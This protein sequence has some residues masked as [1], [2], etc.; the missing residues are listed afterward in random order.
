VTAGTFA[1]TSI[2]L[3]A[4]AAVAGCGRIGLPSLHDAAAQVADSPVDD[5]LA[6]PPADACAFGP[7]MVPA[8]QPFGMVN[9][10]QTDWGVEVSRD[11]LRL[12]FSSNRPDPAHQDTS[13]DVYYAERATTADGFGEPVRLSVNSDGADD[14]DPTLSEDGRELYFARDCIYAATRSPTGG[15]SEW[16]TPKRLDALCPASIMVSGPFLSRDGLRLYYGVVDG[17]T[18]EVRMATRSPGGSFTQAG[19]SVGAPELH[20]IALDDDERTL[21]GENS[22]AGGAQLWR[23]TRPSTSEPFPAGALV[24]ELGDGGRFEDG[25]PSLT[26]D[27]RHLVFATTR[28]GSTSGPS[29]IVI[30]ERSCP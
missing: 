15:P 26:S 8:D 16:S 7:W 22:S 21:Y 3:G 12:V 10:P 27:G 11:G 1:R 6:G 14:S 19:V 28:I 18:T 30:A 13:Y 17:S 20:Y 25:D 23:A 29:D 9:S 5:A 2:L 24:D 4:M